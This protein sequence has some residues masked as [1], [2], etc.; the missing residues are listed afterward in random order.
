LNPN[1]TPR[2][3]NVTLSAAGKVLS[4]QDVRLNPQEYN[5][6]IRLL[7]CPNS[8]LG[9]P[10]KITMKS[11]FAPILAHH[12]A[13][14]GATGVVKLSQSPSNSCGMGDSKQ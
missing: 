6:P 4:Q 5:R 14:S 10:M 11:T 3:I 12:F 7:M 2:Q 9:A 8:A 13:A 1:K